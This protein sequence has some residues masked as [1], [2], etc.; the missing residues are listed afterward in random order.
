[1]K[2]NSIQFLRAVAVILVVY[3]HSIV[4]QMMYSV[5]W[6]QNFHHLKTFG[7][8]G[9]DIFFVLS[10]F[11]ITYVANKHVGVV[12]G[13]QF[14]IK[15]FWRINPVYYIACFLGLFVYLLQL[16][17]TKIPIVNLLKQT[18][19]SFADSILIVPTARD[20]NS[21][22]P[23]PA[24]TVGWTLAFEWLFYLLCFILI[25]CKIKHKTLAL[26]GIILL[27]VLSGILLNPAD[28]RF[29]FLTNPIM[30]EFVL[31]VII[32][33]LYLKFEKTPVY[34]GTVCLGTGLI[35]YIILIIVGFGDVWQHI[36]VIGGSVS[37]TRFIIWGIPSSFIVA[38]CVFLEKN[39]RLPKL[40]NNKWA[41]IT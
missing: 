3:D 28:L 26:S 6:Q 25:L 35:T 5:S 22:S 29:I 38:G 24:L 20:I 33:H 15:R 36:S 32:C 37:L 2:L 12:Q 7:C 23:L 21:Y 9:V 4:L 17:V 40:F 27:L 30:L 18:I 11:I 39:G 41:Q 10:G 19:S 34:V 16:W 13:S 1:M 31:G 8:I 14:L